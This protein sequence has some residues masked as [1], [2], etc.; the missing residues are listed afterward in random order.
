MAVLFSCLDYESVPVSCDEEQWN[1]HVLRGHRGMT[2]REDAAAQTIRAPW[3]VH[4]D[5]K[6][7]DRKL[8]YGFPD[9]TSPFPAERLRVVVRYGTRDGEPY[10]V[11]VTAF[12]S[13][14][15]RE[16][17]PLLWPTASRQA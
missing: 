9:Q 13:K 6:Y 14:S 2:G 17:D 11:V 15:V 3:R 16:G 8:F 12:P 1:G 4:Q 7:P 10:G 5:A